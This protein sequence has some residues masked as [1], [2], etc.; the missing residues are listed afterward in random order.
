MCT[1]TLSTL[2][3]SN[4]NS[5]DE[6][7]KDKSRLIGVDSL[8]T[9]VKIKTNHNNKRKRIENL[10]YGKINEI[11]IIFF[12]FFSWLRLA[13]YFYR[14]HAHQM[15]NYNGWLNTRPF[16]RK[17]PFD[18]IRSILFS[19][20]TCDLILRRHTIVAR[21]QRLA[22]VFCVPESAQHCTGIQNDNTGSTPKSERA[23]IESLSGSRT[24]K[25]AAVFLGI[26]ARRISVG[27][28]MCAKR[29]GCVLRTM[30]TGSL[31]YEMHRDRCPFQCVRATESSQPVSEAISVYAIPVPFKRTTVLK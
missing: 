10:F 3:N 6:K 21:R 8:E 20:L 2:Y 28:M 25:L 13:S 27:V 17:N 24:H 15:R 11:A 4:D 19:F 26:R 9:T 1:G 29:F 22:R 5:C 16:P 7:K 18:F 30:H 14:I 12:V 23:F 31:A